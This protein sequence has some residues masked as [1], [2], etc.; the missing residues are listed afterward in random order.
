[1]VSGTAEPVPPGPAE[2]PAVPRR[3]LVERTPIVSGPNRD[4]RFYVLPCVRY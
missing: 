4:R 3:A 1:M 2:L